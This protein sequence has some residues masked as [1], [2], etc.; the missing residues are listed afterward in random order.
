MK[1]Y[2]DKQFEQKRMELWSNL[3]I[4]YTSCLADFSKEVTKWADDILDAFD[5]GFKQKEDGK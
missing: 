2:T 3:V 4:A 5:K 1:I